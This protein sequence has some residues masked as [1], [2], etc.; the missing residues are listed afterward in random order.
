[1]ESHFENTSQT[2]I[3]RGSRED[4]DR[5]VGERIAA[6]ITHHLQSHDTV[7]LAVPGGRSITGTF[8]YMKSLDLPWEKV[9]I[10]FLDERWV[11]AD[12][13]DSNYRN[14]DNLLL[15][16]IEIPEGNVHIFEPER[17]LDAYQRE[18]EK[19]DNK[20]NI[21]LIGSGEDGHMAS[22]FPGHDGLSQSGPGYFEVHDSPKPPARRISLTPQS[23]QESDLALLLFYGEGKKQALENFQDPALSSDESPVKIMKDHKNLLVVTDIIS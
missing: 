23:L 12:H 1:M 20:I 15:S 18:F 19:H 9:H 16:D 3:E 10:F 22:L 21:A 13:D 11:P 8:D 7:T 6:H 5:L 14:L 4:M 2:H 17:G